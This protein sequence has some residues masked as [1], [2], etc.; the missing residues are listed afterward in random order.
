MVEPKAPAVKLGNGL[1]ADGEAVSAAGLHVFDRYLVFGK[2]AYLR[3]IVQTVGVALAQSTEIGLATCVDC[4]PGVEKDRKSVTSADLL[5]RVL[6]RED[7]YVDEGLLT[8]LGSELV[9]NDSQLALVRAPCGIGIALIIQQEGMSRPTG[10]LRHP[11]LAH[12]LTPLWVAEVP[13]P[14][15]AMVV[16][17]LLDEAA[18]RVGTP[19]EELTSGGDCSAMKVASADRLDLVLRQQLKVLWCASINEVTNP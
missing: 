10:D 15:R 1:V 11:L 9:V 19:C 8:R 17:K 5:A 7:R 18:V 16:L 4:T 12:R 13:R 3:W 6:I 2:P 14:A